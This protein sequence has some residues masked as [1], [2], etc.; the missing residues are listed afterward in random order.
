MH[1]VDPDT[2]ASV[3]VALA[4]EL[5]HFREGDALAP[6]FTATYHLGDTIEEVEPAQGQHQS[7]ALSPPTTVSVHLGDGLGEPT[8]PPAVLRPIDEDEENDE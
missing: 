7:T 6:A 3:R 4:A 1:D 5:T 2:G 8:T